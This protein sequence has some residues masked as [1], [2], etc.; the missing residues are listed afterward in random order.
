MGAMDEYFIDTFAEYLYISLILTDII[1][2]NFILLATTFQNDLIRRLDFKNG[3]LNCILL[4]Y[5]LNK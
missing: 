2:G 1:V 3:R 4:L 5:L